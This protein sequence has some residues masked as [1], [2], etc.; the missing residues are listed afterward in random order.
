MLIDPIACPDLSGVDAALAGRRGGAARR[1]AGPALPGRGRVPAPAS[2]STPSW[3]G[4]CSATRGWRWARCSKRCSASGWPRSIRP[5]TGRSGRCRRRCSGTRRSTWRCSSTC[6]T[7]WRRS[8]LSRGRPSGPGRSSRRR[9]RRRPPPPRADPWRRTSG[10]HRV[11]TRRGLAVVRELWNVRDEIARD[12]DLSPR[13]VLADQAIIE[14]AGRAGDRAAAPHPAAARKDR[15][16]PR[17][18]RAQ[19][20]GALAHRGAPRPRARRQRAA[21]GRRRPRDDPGR[22]PRTAG[23]SATRTPRPGW[24]PRGRRSPP[25]PRRTGCP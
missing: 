24:P 14:A 5:P 21:R 9:R 7:R 4:G 20:L 25:S 3:P 15:R 23:P 10:I 6:A 18:E 1:V 11:R 12:A 22:R 2:C 17:A 8:S 16:I 19:A 13:R